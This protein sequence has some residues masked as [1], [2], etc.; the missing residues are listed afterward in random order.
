MLTIPVASFDLYVTSKTIAGKT[1][2]ELVDRVEEA[3]GVLLREGELI[4]RTNYSRTLATIASEGASALYKVC[5]LT[6]CIYFL[7]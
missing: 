3:R 2:Q 1:L 5:L 6:P 7:P 4:K